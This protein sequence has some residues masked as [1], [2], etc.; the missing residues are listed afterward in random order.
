MDEPTLIRAAQRGD[1]EAFNQLVLFYQDFLFR[2]ARGILRDEDAAADATQ[3][4]F[5]S[6]FR[7]LRA[8][9]GGSL[10]SWLS[11]IVA[12]ACYDSLR[13]SA[14]S[15][16]LPLEVFNREDEEME[17]GT[18]LADPAPSPEEQAE[19][20]EL[21][22]AIQACVQKLPAHYRLAI[23]LVDVEGLSYEEAAAALSAP[24]GTVKSRLARARNFVRRS[25]RRYPDLTPAA[26]PANKPLA[27]NM[28]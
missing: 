7:N 17:P 3:Q 28:C 12:N 20:N 6:A 16:T 26:F 10:R 24:K 5:L 22:N 23:L 15:R 4:A 14:R 21:L 9:R 8:F 13:S 2:I 19:T 11:R 1:L 27:A 25:L 18:W